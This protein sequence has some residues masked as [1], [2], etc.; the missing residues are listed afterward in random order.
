MAALLFVAG[1]GAELAGVEAI[2]FLPPVALHLSEIGWLLT[3][4]VAASWIA[5]LTARISVLGA[6]SRIY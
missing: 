1:T 5:L 6:L 4:P 2:P 3:V